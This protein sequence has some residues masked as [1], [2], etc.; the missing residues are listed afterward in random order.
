MNI[1]KEYRNIEESTETLFSILIYDKKVCDVIKHFEDQMNK[2]KNI[3][4]P[5]KKHKINN[6]LFNF[7]KYLNEQYND[8]NI[9]INNI[10]LIHEKI[11]KYDLTSNE[12]SIAKTYNMFNIFLKVNTTFCIDYFIDYFY[13]FNFIYT[14]KINKTD[15]SIIKM[16]KNKEK[17]LEC[18][19]ITNEQ[20]LLDEIENIRKNHNFK[21]NI[22]IYGNSPYI[23]KINNIKEVIIH[24]DFLNKEEVF[25]LYENENMKKKH[26]LL[27]KKLNDL[28]NEKCNTDLYVF[29]KLKIEIKEAIETYM[30][31]E[32][33][34]EDKKYD[35]LKT[36]ID[37]TYLNFN[38]ITIKS[39]ENGDI[40]DMFI[41]NYNGIMGI[42]YY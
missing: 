11:I 2:A 19:K 12:I 31:K 40:G 3:T 42:K 4:N 9:I 17:E 36:F 24:N 34:I 1:L 20:K 37:E 39:L 22:I 13:N 38:I 14:I 32:L 15:M 41:K 23:N 30:L 18:K 35:K 5:I 8:E 28:K 26:I 16:N 6:R 29:G 21:D 10:F 25:N 27:E 7:I 33:Y